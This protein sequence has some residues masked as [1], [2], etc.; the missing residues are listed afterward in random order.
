MEDR[1]SLYLVVAENKIVK[2]MVTMLYPPGIVMV[3]DECEDEQGE[4]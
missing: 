4:N 1:T 2:T 3:R